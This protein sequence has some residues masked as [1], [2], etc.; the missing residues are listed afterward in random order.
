M[1][2]VVVH[3]VEDLPDRQRRGGVLPDQA[4]GLLVLRRGAVLQPEQVIGFQRLAQL[5]GL[6]RGHPVV[7]V[8]EQ[9]QFRA[10]LVPDRLKHGRQVP[11][12]RPGVPVL[13]Q[14]E[15]PAPGRL[16]VIP[17]PGGLR[18][19]RDPVHGLD[20][21][22]RGLD[23]DRLVPEL[24]VLPDR[25]KQRRKIRT[26]GVPVRAQPVPRRPAQQL[27]HRHPGHLAL[28]VPQGHVD[29][30]DRG[31]RHRTAAPVR[32][33][34]QELPR[35]LDPVRILPD[36]QLRHMLLQIRGHRELTAVQRRI[37]DPGHTILGGNP[38]GHEVPGRAGHKDFSSNDFHSWS[39]LSVSV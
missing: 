25:I 5:R 3:G 24:Q 13:L 2:L 17:L 34:V 35:V 11:Q 27:V 23:P 4:Q 7:P 14:R 33:P 9:R 8:M 22:H 26:R 28:D 6:D 32:G 31:H 10:E 1:R 19:R 38:Q 15:R 20:P 36:Q 16:I 30:G 18:L 21:G 39:R 37:A 12:V 29:G